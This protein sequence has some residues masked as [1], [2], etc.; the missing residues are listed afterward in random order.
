MRPSADSKV[1][2][3][4]VLV[5]ERSC[6]VRI[7]K[8]YTER[9]SNNLRSRVAAGTVA[10]KLSW[11]GMQPSDDGAYVGWTGATT[12][13][14]A[15]EIPREL[16]MCVRLISQGGGNA[17]TDTVSVEFL[18]SCPNA[19][20]VELKPLAVDDWEIIELQS[21]YIEHHLLAQVGVV[22]PGQSIPVWAP[23][24]KSPADPSP[25]LVR[26]LVGV[27]DSGGRKPRCARLTKQTSVTI[28]GKRR[29]SG[30]PLLPSPY[31]W[32]QQVASRVRVLAMGEFCSL[33]Y[34]ANSCLVVV[35]PDFG[36]VFGGAVKYGGVAASAGT[37]KSAHCTN[38]MNIPC[39]M[40]YRS[41]GC[42]SN[43]RD[44]DNVGSRGTSPKALR[45]HHVWVRFHR[46]IPRGHIA[47]SLALR[48][49]CGLEV[50]HG[51]HLRAIMHF[52]VVRRVFHE[53]PIGR[54]EPL[55]LRLIE[56]GAGEDRDT[57]ADRRG[58][59][60]SYRPSISSACAVACKQAV[61]AFVLWLGYCH[62][63]PVGPIVCL[64]KSVFRLPMQLSPRAVLCEVFDENECNAMLANSGGVCSHYTKGNDDISTLLRIGCACATHST[65]SQCRNDLDYFRANAAVHRRN[66]AE[67][68]LAAVPSVCVDE[69]TGIRRRMIIFNRLYGFY[70]RSAPIKR[71]Q[72]HMSPL[73]S[74][75][76]ARTRIISFQSCYTGSLLVQGRAGS[77]KT[78]FV[79]AMT[80]KFCDGANGLAYA[81][82]VR[83]RRLRGQKRMAVKAIFEGVW[84]Q[85]ESLAP[86]LVIWD[87]LDE[88]CPV[89]P[90]NAAPQVHWLAEVLS[91]LVY[92]SRESM[93]ARDHTW[94]HR[95]AVLRRITSMD[96][97]GEAAALPSFACV[98]VM[99]TTSSHP[100]QALHPSLLR[101]GL[102]DGSECVSLLYPKET[103]RRDI[104]RT[105]LQDCDDGDGTKISVDIDDQ[106]FMY[107]ASVMD[108]YSLRD[109][110]VVV[111]R[112]RLSAII[113]AASMHSDGHCALRQSGPGASLGVGAP[114]A[115]SP[116]CLLAVRGRDIRQAI[117]NFIPSSH[118]DLPLFRSNVCWGDVGG[119]FDVRHALKETLEYPVRF[120]RLYACA[121]LRVPAGVL[122][123]GPPGCGKTLLAGAVATECGLNFI[124][125]KGAELLSKYIGASEQ[126]VRE[127]FSRGAAASPCVLFF[128]EFDAIASR[129]GSGGTGVTDRVVNQLLTFLDGIEDRGG[130]YVMAAT[131][132]PDLIDPALLR[133]GRLDKQLFCGF[134]ETLAERMS[135][136]AALTRTISTGE[137]EHVAH[138][139]MGWSE[140]LLYT[141][142]SSRLWRHTTG[143][144]LRAVLYTAQLRAIHETG[145][146]KILL[147][148]VQYAL[149]RNSS[150]SAEDHQRYSAM[151]AAFR[152]KGTPRTH[153]GVPL[154]S[155]LR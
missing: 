2:I 6:H 12:S 85:A 88:L 141:I 126:S 18:P 38:W 75:N 84:R 67:M 151:Y 53:A 120:A 123:Y 20:H 118:R 60:C 140:D 155:A 134:P 81:M 82:R 32:S 10:L 121:P 107:F 106:D 4:F 96:D 63:T 79:S 61:A 52:P 19:T 54:R 11:T 100:R 95:Q 17:A 132:R 104:L 5:S 44:S 143:A 152:D 133:P 130:V 117:A 49:K 3:P 127:L 15:V 145:R 115:E 150:L 14:P 51:A 24:G 109:I 59:A 40:L 68:P 37:E 80:H 139:S 8:V 135:I 78:S 9:L 119:L 90:H 146:E 58:S 114:H 103:A 41:K 98:G 148:H 122:L 28:S 105:L 48:L 64:D 55:L 144:D 101:S 136:L 71:A 35:H 124:S 7:P 110:S 131:S 154:R 76:V 102:F 62:T 16:A 92:R 1:D 93:D 87:D 70:R 57:S 42:A 30:F 26:M 89:R 25:P 50:M 74:R 46:C 149:L 99:G 111:H 83:C 128:D 153:C 108:G 43:G 27:V 36:R 147:R 129:R 116:K 77:G 34:C 94:R 29:F 97:H 142:A 72:T 73:I 91:S 69:T 86:A 138:E 13:R 39:A 23:A 31:S 22:A 47:V 45:A 137:D 65:P 112:A 33:A 56:C 113:G 21:A 66:D 125:V